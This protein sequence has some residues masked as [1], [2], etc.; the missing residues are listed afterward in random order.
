MSLG[1]PRQFDRAA[2]LEVAVGLFWDKGF[3]GTTKRELIE[4]TGVA[5]QSLYN[6]FG[7]KRRL[8]VEALGYYV[9]GRLGAMGE[10]LEAPGSPLANLRALVVGWAREAEDAERRGC[11]L[12][13]A[14][15][16]LGSRDGLVGPFLRETLERVEEL[17]A[18]ALR[19]AVAAGELDAAFDVDGTAAGLACMMNGCMLL[20]R[21]GA[22]ASAVDGAVRAALRLLGGDARGA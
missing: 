15:A 16:E 11:F 7:D 14:L 5:S 18:G 12:C 1:R 20:H 8:F 6:A 10:A 13:N 3:R 21:C 2:A 19:R 22:P 9:D 17:Y 4:A